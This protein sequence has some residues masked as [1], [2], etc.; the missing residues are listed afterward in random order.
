[1]GLENRA[2]AP[3]LMNT[4][5]SRSHTVLTINIIQK[6]MHT[7]PSSSASVTDNKNL[8]Q[9]QQHN[10]NSTISLES[11]AKVPANTQQYTR[12][13][14]RYYNII[15]YHHHQHRHDDDHCHLYFNIHDHH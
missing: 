15:N 13:L 10:H 2:I 7:L 4:T 8:Q 11:I 3:T 9:H 6:V 1:M 12:T 5:S 14:R